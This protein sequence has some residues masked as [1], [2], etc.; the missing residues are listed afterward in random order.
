MVGLGVGTLAAYGQ[1]GDY[2]RFY[3]I[4]PDVVRLARSHFTYLADSAAQ[5]D[6]VLGDARLSLEREAPQDFDMLVLDAFSGDA[7]PTHLLTQE[8]FSVYLRHLRDE[9]LLA[10]HIT[11]RHVDLNPVI[12]G[13]ARHFG[14]HTA[15]IR[16]DINEAQG[17]AAAVWVLIARDQSF[18]SLPAIRAAMDPAEAPIDENPPPLWRDD[19]SNLLQV[20]R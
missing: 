20:L 2:L 6:V 8:A 7:I 5:I 11:N 17:A 12:A 9:G 10:I 18:L 14:L 19:Y 15:R 3:E 4:N 13:L 16:S 1:P